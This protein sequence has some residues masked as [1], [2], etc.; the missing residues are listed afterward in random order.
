M[1]NSA[2]LIRISV[3]FAILVCVPSWAQ[4]DTVERVLQLKKQINAALLNSGRLSP[5]NANLA[6]QDLLPNPTIS[7]GVPLTKGPTL[8]VVKEDMR[9]TKGFLLTS[10]EAPNQ[11]WITPEEL[12]ILFN[13]KKSTWVDLKE[14][15]NMVEEL[16]GYVAGKKLNVDVK[17]YLESSAN[18][19]R[20]KSL[21]FVLLPR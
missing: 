20:N 19:F 10:I 6:E 13:N 2:L 14:V 9:V 12:Q 11:K 15:G 1:K 4:L 17:Y 8:V 16:R 7:V 18:N 5:V 3:F 21:E